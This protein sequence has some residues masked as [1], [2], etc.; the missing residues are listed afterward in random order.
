MI[1]R[2]EY[3]DDSG[4]MV[5]VQE[6]TKPKKLGGEHTLYTRVVMT[7]IKA[8]HSTENQVLEEAVDQHVPDS[9]FSRRWLVRGL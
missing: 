9:T 5:K 2:L 6:R 4:E 3:F 8:N 1:D 7:D